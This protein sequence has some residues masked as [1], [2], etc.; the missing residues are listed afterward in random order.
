MSKENTSEQIWRRPPLSTPVAIRK[1][2]GER[3]HFITIANNLQI[4]QLMY[5][6]QRMER[7]A[8]AV[9]ADHIF[10]LLIR[11]AVSFF[12]K[13]SSEQQNMGLYIKKKVCVSI[14]IHIN[15]A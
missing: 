13:R 12:G 1:V 3:E 6:S 10:E 2:V 11:T 4:I 8:H 5:K 9:G 15:N 14:E 7:N